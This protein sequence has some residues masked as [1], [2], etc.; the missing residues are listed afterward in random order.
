MEGPTGAGFEVP[1]RHSVVGRA[2]S[3]GA[4]ILRIRL[5]VVH[6]ARLLLDSPQPG[7]HRRELV[8]LETGF[9]GDVRVT[10][11]RDVCDRVTVC[12]EE[13]SLLQVKVEKAKGLEGAF[14]P[15]D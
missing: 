13:V 5:Q 15:A 2:P 3:S 10:V 7:L 9:G 14:A 12:D 1:P 4:S 8:A 11:D 6:V